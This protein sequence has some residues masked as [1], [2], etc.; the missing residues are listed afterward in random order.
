MAKRDSEIKL[1][2]SADGSVAVKA[3]NRV[4][5]GI[6][7]LGN[8]ARR[9]GAA[10]SRLTIGIGAAIT[11]GGAWALGKFISGSVEAAE[12]LDV[13][14]RTLAATIE[15][16]GGAANLTAQEIN[17]MAERLDA[18][19]LGSAEEFRAGANALLTFKSVGKDSFESVLRLAKD[20]EA[21][22]LGS[23][24][25]NIIQLGKALEDPAQGL[26]A[27]RRAGVSFSDSQKDVIKQ[28]QATGQ[29]AE[30][31][32]IILQ[33]VAGQ[34]G[35]AASAA[36][37]GL[38]GLRDRAGQLFKDLQEQF[39][40]ARLPGLEAIQERINS[41]LERLR[42]S[43]V[44][45]RFGQAFGEAWDYAA[46]RFLAF[47]ENLD[48][49]ALQAK[50]QQWVES[51]KTLFD[52]LFAK[53]RE[54][55]SITAS[56]VDTAV[57]VLAALKA[58]WLA[59]Y[60][61]V[62]L[63]FAGMARLAANV[64]GAYAT[65]AEAASKVGLVSEE[66]ALKVRAAADTLS[67]A[68][69]KAKDSSIRHF[70]EMKKAGEVVVGIGEAQQ[71]TAA[72]ITDKQQEQTEKTKE[73]EKEAAK[74]EKRYEGIAASADKASEA[75]SKLTETLQD[76]GK[77]TETAQPD[78]SDAEQEK[79][80]QR[81]LDE[82]KAANLYRFQ[83][84]QIKRSEFELTAQQLDA[85]KRGET[86]GEQELAQR[87]YSLEQGGYGT[88]T[89]AGGAGLRQQEALRDEYQGKQPKLEP[90]L[91]LNAR[92]ALQMQEQIAASG[93][94]E[95]PIKFV[96]AGGQ[97]GAAADIEQAAAAVGHRP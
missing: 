34:V 97:S 12:K 50:F 73:G 67:E 17:D 65:V 9:V 3:L 29:T 48:F 14:M 62:E 6:K 84:G 39:G 45:T 38:S 59:I 36:A 58:I 54:L 19:T 77:D 35:G 13:Q 64:V 83:Q 74:L 16:T 49:T 80:R 46:G 56:A 26:T 30:A 53:I 37:S 76:A 55:P 88:E 18:A 2:I 24:Q 10:L 27:L 82:E 15:A 42:D 89:N 32:G 95:V 92:W 25:S 68:S 86:I 43:G 72:T 60:Q 7:G 78:L 87:K 28:L 79:K 47:V 75:T 63:V 8:A 52:S 85:A 71:K 57:R 44:A 96:A 20:L 5:D 51:A 22:G 69:S 61:A 41:L 90:E 66:T 11:A 93:P 31:Q 91:V 40:E 70:Q 23:F 81:R 21:A 94:L 4:R 1:R 33:Q